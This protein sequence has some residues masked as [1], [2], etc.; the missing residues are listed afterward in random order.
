M[1]RQGKQAP[2]RENGQEKGSK[3]IGY[4]LSALRVGDST[5]A[6]DRRFNALITATTYDE[7]IHH[8]RQ[9]LKLLKSKMF[10]ETNIDFGK[11]AQDLYKFL[12]GK[13]ENIR[14]SWAR[15]YYRI[16][17]KGGVESDQQ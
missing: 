14:L 16:Y 10:G 2:A 4:S 13:D 15:A 12:V 3:N 5:A 8:L 7:L 6:I 9:M 11:L 1:Y 17:P